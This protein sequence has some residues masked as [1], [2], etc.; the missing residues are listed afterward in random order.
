[1]DDEQTGDNDDGHVK[2]IVDHPEIKTIYPITYDPI[3]CK[4]PPRPEE[5]S[6]LR[7]VCLLRFPIVSMPSVE[8]VATI[9]RWVSPSMLV[10][11]RSAN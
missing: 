11:N 4:I 7:V 8:A 3:K 9:E 5:M 2:V 1:L 10:L 6:E